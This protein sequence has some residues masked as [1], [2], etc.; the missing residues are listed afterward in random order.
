MAST[1]EIQVIK[2]FFTGGIIYDI[3]AFPDIGVCF[4]RVI[5]LLASI[6]LASAAAAQT[7]EPL[8]F[9]PGESGA[10]LDGILPPKDPVRATE[11]PCFS[12]AV[13]QGQRVSIVVE[14]DKNV[15]V[16]VPGAGDARQVFDFAAPSNLIEI[17]LFQLFPS[18]REA[19][20]TLIVRVE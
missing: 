1:E 19:R 12:L 9:P 4:M 14:G 11:P 6:C 10:R 7:C 3:V 2:Y 16:T 8:R 5:L 13:R 18:T 17:L 15:V 20:Y